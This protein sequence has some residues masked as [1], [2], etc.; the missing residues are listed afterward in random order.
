MALLKEG[1]QNYSKYNSLYALRLELQQKGITLTDQEMT[2]IKSKI[3]AVE[4]EKELAKE[5]NT[6]E[7]NS[8]ARQRE[9]ARLKIDALNKAN[10]S[11]PDRRI[12]YDK[13][14]GDIG[15]TA[16]LDQGITNITEQ[17]RLHY[18][19]ID[20]M[21]ISDQ[22]KETAHNALR[23]QMN[24]DLFDQYVNNM[25]NMGGMWDVLGNT[26]TTFE[27]SATTAITNVLMGTSSISDAMR[28]LANTI[29]NEVVN[30]FVKMGVRWAI[31]QATMLAIGTENQQVATAQAVASGTAITTAM[32]P[33]ATATAVATQG[34]SVGAGMTALMGAFM[35]IPMLIALAGKRKNGGAV[36][37]GS[38]YQ[39]GEGN[40]PEIYQSRSGRQ[41]MIAGDNGR[42]FSNK[43]VMGNGGNMVHVTQNVT[44]NGDGKLDAD[45]LAKFRDQ[46][47][48]VIYEVLADE[49]R[50]A[51]G[52]LA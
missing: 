38:L 2:A 24:S 29:L 20:Q 6:Y 10:V 26:I 11:E 52:M 40:A 51:G 43:Q 37:A 23:R 41:Y 16:S 15:A 35:A 47:R 18:E 19:A 9:L 4:R 21:R 17:Y 30:S 8:L 34:A 39:V 28:S 33:A 32:T 12:E 48:A 3:D 22:E 31:E 50:D 49:K 46:T 44:I 45:T 42:V 5:I 25:K 7:E 36:N 14:L 13:M 1:Y 27:Q